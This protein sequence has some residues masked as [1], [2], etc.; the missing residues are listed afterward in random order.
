MEWLRESSAF[1]PF[2]ILFMAMHLFG[3]GRHGGHGGCGEEGSA[4]IMEAKR[5]KVAA[6]VAE[7]AS[8]KL[9]VGDLATSGG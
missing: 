5:T 2:F 8:D 4:R 7:Y 6:D 3:H 1:F 9:V